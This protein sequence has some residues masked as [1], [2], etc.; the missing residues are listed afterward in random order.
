M[1]Y[2]NEYSLIENR[3]QAQE[4]SWAVFDADK[5]KPKGDT[6]GKSP[7]GIKITNIKSI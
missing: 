6:N 2:P 7:R 4:E 3:A 5:V 1:F